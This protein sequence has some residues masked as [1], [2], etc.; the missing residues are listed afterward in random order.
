MYTYDPRNDKPFQCIQCTLPELIKRI[1]HL[2][3]VRSMTF[4][5]IWIAH[6]VFI[7]MP[8]RYSCWKAVDTIVDMHD[9]SL[10][11]SFKTS[12]ATR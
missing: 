9:T 1:L 10:K 5:H 11:G 12:T 7:R 4:A 3:G 6:V 2:L 8:Q